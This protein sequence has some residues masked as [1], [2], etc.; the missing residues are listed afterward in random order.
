MAKKQAKSNTASR[1]VSLMAPYYNRLVQG[2][3]PPVAAAGIV[4]NMMAESSMNHRAVNPSNHRG[5]LQNDRHIYNYHLK[6]YGDYSL[7]SQIQFILDGWHGKIKDKMIQSRF[8]AYRK[9]CSNDVAKNAAYF[10]K[11]YEKSG[12]QLLKK[13]MQYASQMLP[14][15]QQQQNG[16]YANYDIPYTENTGGQKGAP[17]NFSFIHPTLTQQATQYKMLHPDDVGGSFNNV[18][19]NYDIYNKLFAENENEPNFFDTLESS[20]DDEL[21]GYAAL[22]QM[23]LKARAE[24]QQK[25][26]LAQQAPL[27]QYKNFLDQFIPKYE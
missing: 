19:E 2:G 17:I 16:A 13:R 6:R 7:D 15:V 24:Q 18:L 10:E 21:T 8:N 25:A 11:D 9:H 14:L 23:I 4:G 26:R 5:L 20:E 27:L 22:E 3:I 12:G 1:N